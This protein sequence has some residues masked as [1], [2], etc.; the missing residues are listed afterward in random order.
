MCGGHGSLRLFVAAGLVVGGVAFARTRDTSETSVGNDF[1]VIGGSNQNL[2]DVV[3]FGDDGT[4]AVIDGGRTVDTGTYTIEVDQ[5]SIVSEWVEV[6]GPEHY[7]VMW[8]EPDCPPGLPPHERPDDL[9]QVRGRRRGVPV[10]VRYTHNGQFRS[11]VGRVPPTH[12]RCERTPTRRVRSRL[13]LERLDE[14]PRSRQAEQE[15]PAA[16][17]ERPSS[18]RSSSVVA[19]STTRCSTQ[20]AVLPLFGWVVFGRDPARFSRS[21]TSSIPVGRRRIELPFG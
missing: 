21:S 18:F 12:A 4:F 17:C 20:S 7:G 15:L 10:R 8:A 11:G 3:T 1:Q 16:P 2:P 6:R 9:R 14:A 5:I 13:G 19:W